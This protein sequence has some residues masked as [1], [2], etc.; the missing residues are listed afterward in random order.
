MQSASRSG[1]VANKT[2]GPFPDPTLIL[3]S[4]SSDI[5]N[6][7]RPSMVFHTPYMKSRGGEG[8]PWSV[9]VTVLKSPPPNDPLI[10]SV[11]RNLDFAL[12][13]NQFLISQPKRLFVQNLTHAF[14]LLVSLYLAQ[15]IHNGHPLFAILSIDSQMYNLLK[16]SRSSVNHARSVTK[17][18]TNMVKRYTCTDAVTVRLWRSCT[19]NSFQRLVMN[20]LVREKWTC[21]QVCNKK[22]AVI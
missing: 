17:K 16:N 3:S 10:V 14:F 6:I 4:S 1:P 11:L 7:T 13:W 2:I 12:L 21:T 20:L 15:R 8:R 18:N 22:H 19:S 9:W 5:Q